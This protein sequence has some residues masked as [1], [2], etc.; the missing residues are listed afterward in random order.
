MIKYILCYFK[1][2]AKRLSQ[3]DV[4]FYCGLWML[5]LLFCGTIEQK[6]IGLWQAQ[7]KYFSSFF[8]WF[9]SFP[10]P[11]GWAAMGII[12]T[13]LLLKTVFYT[14]NIKK[15]LG[16][17]VTHIGI[18]LLL[19]GGFITALFSQEGYIVIPEGEKSNIVSDYHDVEL[20]ITNKDSSE[21]ITVAQKFLEQRKIS[22]QKE[23][24]SKE[25]NSVLTEQEMQTIEKS[26]FP[27]QIKEFM[28][29][30][31]VVK[32]K[33]PQTDPFKG[34]ARIFELKRKKSEK[35]NESNI[36]GLTF[37]IPTGE[38]KQE[39]YSIFERM[40]IKQ[41]VKW[42]DGV[43]IVELRPIRTYLPFSI[44]LIDFEKSYYPGTDK[45]RSY[46]SSVEIMDQSVK[47]KRMIK[48][49]QPL[50]YKGYTFYQSSFIEEE[51]SES[52]VLAAVKNTGRA[53]P[54]VSSLIIC[55][56]L[57]IHIFG[58]ISFFRKPSNEKS[59]RER[60]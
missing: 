41:T 12:L 57:L 17:L 56:G 28:K 50:R 15:N 42:K 25:S 24:S 33:T 30:T 19:V 59:V 22:F 40:P 5:V 13:S 7:S 32:R 46:Q 60:V 9:Y 3:P 20:A 53:F 21:T 26:F 51:K 49:N 6:Y 47:Q 35:V 18:I 14:K 44:H 29:N 8:F 37:Y 16:S 36:A 4:F 11:A 27:L 38:G 39:I 1:K 54:Y 55:F 34:F 10:L 58:N 48:M 31:E 52:T 43:Y 45:P 2:V 23:F